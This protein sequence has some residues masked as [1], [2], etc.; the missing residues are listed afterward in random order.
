MKPRNELIQLEKKQANTQN[1]LDGCAKTID[2]II[3][4]LN[5]LTPANDGNIE[6]SVAKVK[7]M[8]AI[9]G[10]YLASMQR[11]EVMQVQSPFVVPAPVSPVGKAPAFDVNVVPFPTP[12]S[13]LKSPPKRKLAEVDVEDEPAP[14]RIC[15]ETP[16]VTVP[17]SPQLEKNTDPTPTKTPRV[18]TED[19]EALAATKKAFNDPLYKEALKDAVDEGRKF[20]NAQIDSITVKDTKHGQK[21]SFRGHA[22]FRSA[23]AVQKGTGST[24]SLRS[25]N[26][27]GPTS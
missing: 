7:N 23:P 8:H 25:G 5:L 2:G 6:M 3:G 14:K 13:A 27:Y 15:V 9:L 4:H 10:A 19:Q 16:V 17:A 18:R 24:Y 20:K 26:T 12:V 11:D 22:F 1:L 21:V